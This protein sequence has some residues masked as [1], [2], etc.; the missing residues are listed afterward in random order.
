MGKF[1]LFVVGEDSADPGEWSEGNDH[2]IVVATDESE[3]TKLAAMPGRVATEI[4]LDRPI[5][6]ATFESPGADWVIA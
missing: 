4:P 5:V 2:A 6:L 1:R 3:A